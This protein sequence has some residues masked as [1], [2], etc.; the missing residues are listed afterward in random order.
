GDARELGDL[1]RAGAA[2]EAFGIAPLA[3][4]QIRLDV[5]LVKCVAARL[6]RSRA[7]GP[8]GRDE[9]GDAEDARIR[10]ER[11]NLAHPPDILDTVLRREAE[12][13]VEAAAHVVAVENVDGIAAAEQVLLRRHG[14]RRFAG[15][16][17][18]RE[19]QDAAAMAEPLGA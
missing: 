5:D 11:R 16:G 3:G 6:A 4:L 9:G 7:I 12:V 8:V 14:E 1:A 19:P 2:I 18:T 17:Q 13:R 15:A 10:E